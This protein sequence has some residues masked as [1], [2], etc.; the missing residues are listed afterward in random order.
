[1]LLTTIQF[2]IFSKI[3]VEERKD[4]YNKLKK[5]IDKKSNISKIFNRIKK[6]NFQK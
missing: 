2:Y 3:F 6:R 1:M 4:F 5:K